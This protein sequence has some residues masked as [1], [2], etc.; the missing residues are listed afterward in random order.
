MG[1]GWAWQVGLGRVLDRKHTVS[2]LKAL[3]KYNFTPDV[4]PWRATHKEGRWYAVPGDGGLI[5]TTNPKGEKDAFGDPS[6]WQFGYFNECMS[7][8]EHQVAGH[9]IAEGLVQEGL[10]VIRA[11]HDRYR[12]DYRNPW[13]EIE[14]S[15]HY[16]RA[17]A[18]YGCFISMC[19]FEHHGPKKSIGFSPRITPEDF[20]APFTSAAGWGTYSQ[21][22][23]PGQQECTIDLKYGSLTV[24]TLAFNIGKLVPKVVTVQLG[25][26]VIHPKLAIEGSRVLVLLPEAVTVGAGQSITVILQKDRPPIDL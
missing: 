17:M 9:M 22:R 15:D 6:A 18:S 1:Q 8:F 19:G 21:K 14:C 5:M 7:G 24:Q 11:I 10:T 26:Q 16:A 20:R 2:A 4:G 25:D 23:S 12:A 13:N 3:Y